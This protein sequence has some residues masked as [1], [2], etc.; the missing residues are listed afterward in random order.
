MVETDLRSV[1]PGIWCWVRRPRGIARGAFGSRTSYAISV[2][3]ET[4][5]LDPLVSGGD[6]DPAL[7]TLDK[8]VCEG[9]RVRVFV[10]MPFHTRSA[11]FLWQRYLKFDARIYGHPDIAT[12]LGDTSGFEAVT[13][14][15]EIEGVAHFHAIGQPPRSEQPV[16]IP[17][18]RALVFGD[19][20]VNIGDHEL[21]LWD[22]PL[23]TDK[24]RRWW[25][26]RYLPTLEPLLDLQVDHILVTHGEPVTDGLRI[27]RQ[28]LA[29]QPWQRPKR[30]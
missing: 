7:T 15:A 27:L 9:R 11:E 3:Q 20:V 2:G 16:E 24:R 22:A 5:L 19:S 1:A 8:L 21:R 12:R 13:G 29:N 6:G 23:E 30:G 10:T 4:L 25:S 26:E 18:V 28:A 14:P 17:S